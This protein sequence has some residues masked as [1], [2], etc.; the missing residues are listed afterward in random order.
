MEWKYTAANEVDK[1]SL[2]DCVIT[3]ARWE[4]GDLILSFE[5]GFKALNILEQNPTRTVVRTSDFELVFPHCEEYRL[6]LPLFGSRA[7]KRFE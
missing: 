7:Y 3:S 2:H 6:R 4:N 1:I 5:D